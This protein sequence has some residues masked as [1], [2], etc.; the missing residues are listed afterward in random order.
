[1]ENKIQIRNNFSASF[2]QF[3]Q[4]TRLKI[5]SIVFDSEND[6]WNVGT[7]EFTKKIINRSHIVLLIEDNENNLFGAYIDARINSMWLTDKDNSNNRSRTVDPNAFVFSL[8]R[9]GKPSNQRF[10]TKDSSQSFVLYDENST[11]LFHV[12]DD[13]NHYDIDI[14]RKDS[15]YASI[16]CKGSYEYNGINNPLR[17]WNKCFVPKRFVVIQLE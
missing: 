2:K 3:E 13:Y 8:I 16:C 14:S 6:D 9:N 4:W 11:R 12:G 15:G 1:M 17:D 7:C 10:M 5:L